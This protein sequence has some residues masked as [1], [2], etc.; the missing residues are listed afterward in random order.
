MFVGLRKVAAAKKPRR[1]VRHKFAPKSE[2]KTYN[3]FTPIKGQA[4][5]LSFIRLFGRVRV[6]VQENA[7]SDEVVLVIEREAVYGILMNK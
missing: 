2:N 3:H 7:N 5:A 4:S 6:E 1:T